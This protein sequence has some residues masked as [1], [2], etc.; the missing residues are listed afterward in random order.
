[1]PK[2]WWEEEN[3]KS[4]MYDVYSETVPAESP[5]ITGYGDK[6]Y[7]KKPGQAATNEFGA[8]VSKDYIKDVDTAMTLPESEFQ[9][10]MPREPSGD[11]LD[12]FDQWN[13]KVGPELNAMAIKQFG[14][15]RSAYERGKEQRSRDIYNSMD[16]V[17]RSKLTPAQ[18]MSINQDVE[19]Y[20]RAESNRVAAQIK[21]AVSY[22]KSEYDKNMTRKLEAKRNQREWDES[23][24]EKARVRETALSDRFETGRS[25]AMEKIPV[26]ELAILNAKEELNSRDE[27]GKPI[28]HSKEKIAGLNK[29][30]G[31]Y[32]TMIN[33]LSK[34][35]K[36]SEQPEAA[37]KTELLTEED[38]SAVKNEFAARVAK[39]GIT[40]K[41]ALFKEIADKVKAGKTQKQ[42]APVASKPQIKS[43]AAP[44]M[45]PE[46]PIEVSSNPNAA[47]VISGPPGKKYVEGL[48]WIDE[49]APVF[50]LQERIMNNPISRAYRVNKE[51]E[52]RR[53]KRQ[54]DK[55]KGPR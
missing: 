54:Q 15:P 23:Q 9:K 30:I 1:M 51:A 2:Q 28:T 44:S 27:L 26:Y 35:Y 10:R 40:D 29:I 53:V 32:E 38:K 7:I 25:A 41:A 13:K 6:V 55:Y 11:E 34:K 19:R 20:G 45:P 24:T 14:D 18:I 31:G 22:G 36:L 37:P 43:V 8:P 50:S 17:T 47:K 4:E 42:A 3:P 12:M 39:G 48:G 49:N 5:T 21:E 33:E 52:T 16:D 46:P